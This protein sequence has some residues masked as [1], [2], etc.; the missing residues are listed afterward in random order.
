[1][2]HSAATGIVADV[3]ENKLPSGMTKREYA[4]IQGFVEKAVQFLARDDALRQIAALASHDYSVYSHS[5]QVFVYATTMLRALRVQ[6]DLVVAT[7]VGA[8]LHDLG[9]TQTAP[10]LN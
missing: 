9:R 3:F 1:M 6:D 10:N 2:L 7:G 5:V 8:M 4:R